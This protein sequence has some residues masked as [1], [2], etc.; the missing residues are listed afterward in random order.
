MQSLQKNN[1]FEEKFW[2]DSNLLMV[3]ICAMGQLLKFTAQTA[4]AID[5][6]GPDASYNWMQWTDYMSEI[7]FWVLIQ[8]LYTTEKER[9]VDEL[10]AVNMLLRR[11]AKMIDIQ[12]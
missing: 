3:M 5:G 2:T 11:L 12:I 4:F 7:L 1:T 6:N 10:A 8:W 9:I